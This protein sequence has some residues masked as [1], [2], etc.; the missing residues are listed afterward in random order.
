VGES[1]GDQLPSIV[2]Q[3]DPISQKLREI[4]GGLRPI[5]FSHVTEPAQALLVATLASELRKTLWILCPSVRSQE[6]LYES[7][8][9]WQPNALF[10][11]EADQARAAA[12]DDEEDEAEVR[13]ADT[14]VAFYKNDTIDL[15]EIMRDEFYLAVP[16]K[17]LCRPDCRGLCAVCGVNRNRETCS[18]RPE[19]VDPRMEPLKKLL[20]H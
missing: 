1:L 12:G 13:E 6:L 9:N 8:L 17:P 2:A 4:T 18:C 5:A 16:M 15:G 20:D 3:A 11:P 10:L 19:W 7:L 14:G